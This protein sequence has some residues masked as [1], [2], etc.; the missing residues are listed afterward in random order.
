MGI[1]PHRKA[2]P[3]IGD[4]RCAQQAPQAGLLRSEFI[5]A[6]RCE[7]AGTEHIECSEK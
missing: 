1:D 6:L 7:M 5:G 3:G 2:I 4:L